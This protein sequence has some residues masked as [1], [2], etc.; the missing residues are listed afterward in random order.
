MCICKIINMPVYFINTNP[1]L[2]VQNKDWIQIRYLLV[3][4]DII[5]DFENINK[6]TKYIKYD[7]NFKLKY[8]NNIIKIPN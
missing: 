2:V 6:I 3:K 5:E 8:E 1:Y 4:C 7:N